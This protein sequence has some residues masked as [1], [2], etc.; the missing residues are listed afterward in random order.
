MNKVRKITYW[1]VTIWLALGMVSTGI[2]QITRMEEEVANFTNLGYPLYLMT[3]VGI[4]K[5]LGVSAILMPR[6]PLIKE[7]AYAGFFFLMTG[8]I[9]S[10]FIQHGS[11]ITFFGPSLLLLLTILSWYL[12]PASRKIF[13]STSK[14]QNSI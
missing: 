13:I 11:P 6:I 1:I 12:R 9:L 2:V 3:I 10:H 5:I 14:T 8:A 4:W 7:W